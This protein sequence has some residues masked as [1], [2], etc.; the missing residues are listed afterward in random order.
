MT[1]GNG[2]DPVGYAR[3][4]KEHQFRKG[5]SGNPKGRPKKAKS[6]QNL[7]DR[8]LNQVVTV[9][10]GGRELRLTKREA[11]VKRHVNSAMTGNT[12]AIEHLLRYCSD[13]GLAD[14][15]E[16]R[17]EDEQALQAALRREARKNGDEAGE[18]APG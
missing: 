11:I 2:D 6:L 8:E 17:A 1:G 18:G 4:P 5:Q 12:R 15:F 9:K 10:E 3:P 16:L 7:M 13:H 14:P